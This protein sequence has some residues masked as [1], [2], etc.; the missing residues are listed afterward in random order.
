MSLYYVQKLIYQ[1]NRDPAVRER[2]KQDPAA[3]LH[4][5]DLTDEEREALDKPDIGLLYVYGVNGQLL[6]HYAALRGMQWFAYLEAMREG[7][8]RYG[9]VR[10]GL[11]AMKGSGENPGEAQ[12]RNAGPRRQRSGLATTPKG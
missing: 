10:A 1:L 12:V 8:R 7:I 3:V 11:Y 2:Y 4:D 5:Y 6:M 9:P